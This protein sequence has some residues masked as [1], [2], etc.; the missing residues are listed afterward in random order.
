VLVLSDMTRRGKALPHWVNGGAPLWLAVP[1]VSTA[2]MVGFIVLS[3]PRASLNLNWES[4]ELLRTIG[5]QVAS[6]LTEERATRALA[7]SES[8][9]EYNRKF[10]FIVHD[11][12]NL[13]SQLGMMVANIKRY[14]D[15]PEFRS[16]MIRTLENSVSRLGGLLNRLRSDTGTKRLRE[17]ID[18]ALILKETIGEL[19]FG[20]VSIEA[21]VREGSVWV[22]MD[23]DDLRSV[24]THLVSNAIEASPE[25]GAVRVRLQSRSGRVSIDIEDKGVGMDEDF[26]RSELFVPRRSSKSK[27]HGIGAFQARE[28]LRAVGGDIEVV[29]A[30]GVGTLMRVLIPG[31]GHFSELGTVEAPQ[32]AMVS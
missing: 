23:A 3:P 30:R 14:S 32:E 10:A 9:M 27:G 21:D 28:T 12:K 6:Y 19:S 16:D 8:I 20:S 17:V 15:H 24:L 29:S 25:G 4:F 26:I 13:S 18:P 2:R 1:L 5:R 11:V 31:S 22:R 7:D